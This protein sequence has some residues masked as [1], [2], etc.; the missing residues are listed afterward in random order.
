VTGPRPRE[1]GTVLEL[2]D[3]R[4]VL[5]RDLV[6]GDEPALRRA[7]ESA[8]PQVLRARFGGGVPPFEVLADRLR[9]LDG[10]SRYAVGVFDEQGD[11]VGVGEYVQSVPGS[12]AEVALVV[13]QAWQRQGIGTAVLQRLAE[14]AVG[15]GISIATAQVSGSN[16]QVLELVDALPVAHTVSYD[17]GVGTVVVELPDLARHRRATRPPRR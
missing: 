17:H 1:S 14:H 4:R 13:N 7:F 8:D 16:E 10:A 6:A 11:V 3:G 2:D 12:P 5:I 15:V 9:R